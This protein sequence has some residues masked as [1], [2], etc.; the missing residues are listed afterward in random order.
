MEDTNQYGI[1]LTS[2]I[3]LHRKYFEEMCKLLGIKC[4]YRAPRPDKHYT[5]YTEIESNY[6]EPILTSCIFEEHPT[7]QSLKKMGW[8]SELQD[9][10][11]II[12]VIYDLPYIQQGS[13]FILP[14]GLDSTRGR[15]FRVTKLMNSIVYP[16]SITCELVPEYE[17]DFSKSSY[18]HKHD[19]LNL[20]S[21]E[22]E[23]L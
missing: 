14:S 4:I 6:F 7:Q 13:L 18:D 2:D 19:S 11:S 20:L 3:K 5:T 9:S 15:L 12:H 22:K 17:N 8:I 1:L 10:S 16:A 21:E 23:N